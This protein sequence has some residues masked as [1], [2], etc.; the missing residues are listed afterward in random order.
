MQHYF[1]REWQA[2]LTIFTQLQ[3]QYHDKK[4]YVIYID[5][6]HKYQETPPPK[7]WDGSFV[8]TEK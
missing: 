8:R 1:K 7:D 2:A 3:Q 6:I 5:R 4:I